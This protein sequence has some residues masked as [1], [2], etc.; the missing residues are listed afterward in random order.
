MDGQKKLQWILIRRFIE[1]LFLVGVTEY[2]LMSVLNNLALPVVY[3]YFFPHQERNLTYG[4]AQMLLELLVTLGLL[5]MKAIGSLFPLTTR[6]LF[7]RIFR[8]TGVS[9][10]IVTMSRGRAF[11]LF[12]AVLA[13]T[14]LILL[15]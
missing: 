5:M 11:L 12:L 4:N 2:L 1:I 7:G 15:P 8:Q 13:G 3:D 14:L 6:Q 9:T 10:A